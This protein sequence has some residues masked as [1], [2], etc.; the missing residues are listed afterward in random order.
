MVG[1]STLNKKLICAIATKLINLGIDFEY[2]VKDNCIL[3]NG[4]TKRSV[5]STLSPVGIKEEDVFED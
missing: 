3:I 1:I 2:Q 4:V 5:L